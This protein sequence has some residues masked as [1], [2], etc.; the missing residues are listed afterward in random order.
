MGK[1]LS[2]L[3]GQLSGLVGNN[4]SYNLNGKNVTRMK[5]GRTI[6]FKNLSPDQKANCYK[7]E[8]TNDFFRDILP[9]LKAGFSNKAYG[10]TLNYHNLA[11]SYN[12]INALKGAYPNFEMDYPQ[13]RF[14]SGE[15]PMP[16]LNTL[17]LT[18]EGI[19]IGWTYSNMETGVSCTDQTMVL[20]HFPDLKES[21]Y[22]IYGVERNLKKQLILLP[23]EFHTSRLEAYLSFTSD[24]RKK[25]AT[26]IYL[27]RLN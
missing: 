22:I 8:V 7:M 4:V 27:G 9:L 6:K 20:L 15:L 11:T 13:V 24:D 3:Y 14:S 25:V 19:E 1:L 16:L 18:D 17:V 2:G 23:E 10:T 26:S 5:S 12:K 21:M